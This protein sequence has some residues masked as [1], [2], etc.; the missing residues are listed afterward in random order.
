LSYGVEI[1]RTEFYPRFSILL[2]KAGLSERAALH[3]MYPSK[4]TLLKYTQSPADKSTSKEMG[5]KPTKLKKYLFNTVRSN[6]LKY[7]Q[8]KYARL[9]RVVP[10][11]NELCTTP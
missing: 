11:L 3:G 1:Q 8:L 9:H 6:M 10:V 4:A 7:Q 5:I 2:T